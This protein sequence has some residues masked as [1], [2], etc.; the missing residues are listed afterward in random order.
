M[1][2]KFP[3]NAR[4]PDFRTPTK[5]RISYANGLF[6]P[7]SVNGSEPKYGATLI[8]DR[9]EL[10]YYVDLCKKVA[11]A[12]W[13]S[14]GED[15][16]KQGLIKSPI[17]MGDGKEARSKE[18]GELLAGMG[19][20]VFF[21]R[22]IANKDNPPKVYSYQSG[23]HTQASP[24]EVY[25]GCYGFAVLSLFPWNHPMS[26]DGMSFGIQMFQKTAD[27]DSLGGAAPVDSE[28]WFVPDQDD[29]SGST[30]QSASNGGGDNPFA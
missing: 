2:S 24:S 8:F 27:G 19:P 1:A 5:C 17:L 23:P 20:D 29:P 6:T 11:R 22:C 9:K 21:I 25:S 30:Q 12:A 10:P 18:N 4:I 15:R 7:R 26:G 28:K 13:P 3:P 16:L 14:T